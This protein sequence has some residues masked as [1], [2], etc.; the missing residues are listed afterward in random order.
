MLLEITLL[1]GHIKKWWIGTSRNKTLRIHKISLSLNLYKIVKKWEKIL[2]TILNKKERKS[3][4]QRLFTI[5]LNIRLIFWT[6]LSYKSMPSSFLRF[7]ECSESRVLSNCLNCAEMGF[8][9]MKLSLCVRNLYIRILK[10]LIFLRMIWLL[11]VLRC[12]LSLFRRMG[13]FEGLLFWIIKLGIRIKWRLLRNL[14][15]KMLL[16][17]FKYIF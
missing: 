14:R 10:L 16:L 13:M 7:L 12:C 2:S 11:R 5:S 1:L 17:K 8:P 4:N 9:I 3:K 6:F 15:K